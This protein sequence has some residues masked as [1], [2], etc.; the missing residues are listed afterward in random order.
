MY[1]ILGISQ[2]LNTKYSVQSVRVWNIP[3]PRT[4]KNSWSGTIRACMEYPMYCFLTVAERLYNT[5]VYG[6]SLAAVGLIIWALVQSVRVWN[7]PRAFMVNLPPYGTICAC[8]EYLQYFLFKENAVR[9]NPCMYGIY[10][11]CTDCHRKSRE[12]L[13]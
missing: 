12:L 10:L 4:A 7:I 1:D 13:F 2:F 5:C 9:Y 11:I 6:I 8:M 3:Q